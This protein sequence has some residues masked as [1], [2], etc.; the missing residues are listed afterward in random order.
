MR[1]IGMR[2][3]ATVVAVL[4]V[5]LLGLSVFG[6]GSVQALTVQGATGAASP[7]VSH[8]VNAARATSAVTSAAAPAAAGPHPGTLQIYEVAPGGAPTV[9]PAVAY[10]T[11]DDEPITNVYQ[12]LIAFNGTQTGPYYQNW[13]PEVATCVPGSPACTAQFGSSLVYNNATTGAPQY[14]TFEID[15]AAHFYDPATG[16]S[17]GVYP[18]DVLFSFARTFSFANLPV[19]EWWNGWINAQAVLPAGNSSWDGGI[20]APYNNTPNRVLSAFMINDSAYCPTSTTVATNGCITFNVGASG[21]AWPYFLELVSDPLGGSITPCGTFTYLNAG[22]PGFLGTSAPKGDGPCLLPG[23]A[24]SSTQ[25]GYTNFVKSASPTLW[26]AVQLLSA[27]APL[28]PQP[29][30]QST[31]V[32]SGPYYAVGV[33]ASGGPG[34][35]GGYTLHANPAYQQPTGCAGQAQCQPAPGHYVPNV[36]VY[37]DNDDSLGLQ[38]MIAGQADSAGFDASHTST[39]LQLV[40]SGKYG[41][42]RNITTGTNWFMAFELNFSLANEAAVD[43]IGTLNVPGNFLANTELRQF[44]V[45]AYPYDTIQNTVW[46]VDGVVTTQEMGGAIPPAQVSYYPK[47]VSWPTGNPD[48]NASHIGGAAWWWAQAVAN[49][50]QLASCTTASPCQWAIV[51]W[52][53]SPSLDTAIADWI[54]EVKTLSGGRL[55]PYSYDLP[56]TGF[57]QNVFLGNGQGSLPVYN[58][59]W[60]PDYADPTDYLLPMWEPN[61]TFTYG[62]ALGSV[63][64]EA[65]YNAPSCGHTGITWA[66]LTYWA[67][68]PGDQVQTACEGTAYQ[69]MLGWIGLAAHET[70]LTKRALE[71]NLVE[72]IGNELA[73][74]VYAYAQVYNYDYG[75]WLSP[76]GI[77][78]NPSVG[79]GGVQTWFTWAYASNVY[80]VYFNETGLPSG[81]AW[82]VTLAGVTQSSTT[83]SIEFTGQTNGTYPY[84]VAFVSGYGVTPSNGTVTINGASLSE[85]IAFSA[86]VAP[87]FTLSFTEGG[88][89]SNT[90]WSMVVANIGAQTSQNPTISYTLPA[91]TYNYAPGTVI[92]YTNSGAG[93]STIVAANVSVAVSYTGVILS[94]YAITFASTGLPPSSTW[95]VNLGGYSQTSSGANI[96]FYE[97]NGT[98][99]FALTVPAS[100]TPPASSGQVA[101]A[102]ASVVVA[103]PLASAGNGFAVT[104]AETGL[105]TGSAWNVTIGGFGQLSTTSSIVFTLPNGTYSWMTSTIGGYTTSTWSGTVTVN[106]SAVTVKVAFVQFTY[107]VTFFE[108]GLTTGTSWN[109]TV[110]GAT[111]TS[112]TYF[113]TV[114][115]PNGTF[116]FSVGVPATYVATPASGNV[117]VAAGPATQVVIFGPIPTTYAVTFTESGLPSGGTWSVYMNGA[118]LSSTTGTIGFTVPNGTYT[119]TVVVPSGYTAT[120]SAT[121]NTLSVNGAAVG[122]AITI[123]PVVP[124]IQKTTDQNF[125]GTLAYAL[126]GV[127]AVL[128]L[129]FLVLAIYFARRKPPMASPPQTWSGSP[130]SS[131]DSGQPP[132]PPPS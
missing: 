21:L 38:E 110:N 47:N 10:Y 53:G 107:A 111:T 125:L 94:T 3:Y 37:W 126:I 119:F 87:F 48:T 51:G 92:G 75:S 20:H 72:H 113:L 36:V 83:S 70:D 69:Q 2:R 105:P 100:V 101:V 82:A 124:V 29:G 60:V 97:L 22:L 73:F 102:G 39:V 85:N 49:D 6:A 13:T 19:P 108:G 128:A 114:D 16:A 30:V 91:G 116:A 64:Y 106:G 44:L 95:S 84:T 45:H 7:T 17:W 103:V 62:M 31:M 127:M 5:V 15:S 86:L 99:S 120:S 121:G 52:V 1:A 90:T 56:G 89:V 4:V 61:G 93:A 32:G 129:V 131:G 79:G 40:N 9:D 18:S 77:N 81:T 41:L 11:V 12:T 58:W 88:L 118:S 76:T 54:Q 59:G 27:P 50:S 57:F 35:S 130:P 43:P 123:S 78:T 66:N 68:Q 80:N 28:S 55:A 115:L 132:S 8:T 74:M 67:F 33:S 71:F 122:V 98:Y 65:A 112:T 117:T 34:G 14:Y 26:D 25:S 23:N 46:T 96:T 63:M 104:F 109:I 24:T 42:Y